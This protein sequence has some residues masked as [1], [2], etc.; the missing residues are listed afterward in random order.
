M[1]YIKLSEIVQFLK[2]SIIVISVL[3]KLSTLFV[4]SHV[5]NAKCPLNGG[6]PRFWDP[7][8]AFLS[9]EK[10]CPGT[11]LL[12]SI[13]VTHSKIMWKFFPGPNLV[14]PE[15]RCPM[16]RGFRKE[17]FQCNHVQQSARLTYRQ[18]QVAPVVSYAAFLLLG[19]FFFFTEGLYVIL[20]CK[21]K[22]KNL[23]EKL[24]MGY[25]PL[26]RYRRYYY[27]QPSQLQMEVTQIPLHISVQ[28]FTITP[29]SF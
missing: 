1:D 8:N 21:N 27:G 9:P 29:I 25:H 24:L 18:Q 2:A 7:E 15:W 3:L 20:T 19:I 28:P 6:Q 23:P 26:S 13:A 22:N 11:P 5:L 16:N 4:V 10:R 12:P 14:S 17:R